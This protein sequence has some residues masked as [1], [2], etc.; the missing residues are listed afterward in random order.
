MVSSGHCVETWIQVNKDDLPDSSVLS[1]L[2]T[3]PED[4]LIV[5][6]VT[7]EGASGTVD[8]RVD[9]SAS[10]QQWVGGSSDRGIGGRGGSSRFRLVRRGRRAAEGGGA[11]VGGSG[12]KRGIRLCRRLLIL[13]NRRLV[14]LVSRWLIELISWRLAV[15]VGW[16]VV[17]LAELARPR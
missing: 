4:Y 5:V 15:L 8:H 14:E 7:T 1:F 2:F 13:V 16:R 12:A 11:E 6:V 9:N 17:G 10:S 3:E